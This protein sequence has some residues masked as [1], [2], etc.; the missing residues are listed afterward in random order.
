R[1]W[2]VGAGAH[3][4]RDRARRAA[5]R[6]DL[7]APD[8]VGVCSHLRGR[9]RHQRVEL[10]QVTERV[11]RVKSAK[12][13]TALTPPEPDAEAP[14]RRRLQGFASYVVYLPVLMVFTLA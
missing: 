8:P 14:A 12:A 7:G 5:R 13:P 10:A 3:R 1:L 4:R 2:L 11:K 9:R 6:H